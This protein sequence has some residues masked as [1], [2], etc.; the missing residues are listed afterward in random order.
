MFDHDH[1]DTVYPSNRYARRAKQF[2]KNPMYGPTYGEDPLT[3]TNLELDPNNPPPIVSKH[4]NG[5]KKKKK[6]A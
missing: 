3:N 1:T 5:K 2:R 6:I 4:R